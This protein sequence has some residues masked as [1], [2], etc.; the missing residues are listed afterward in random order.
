MNEQIRASQNYRRSIVGLRL[1]SLALLGAFVA[2][3]LM[4][5]PGL[6]AI[7]QILT[8]MVFPVAAVGILMGWIGQLGMIKEFGISVLFKNADT[9][10]RDVFLGIPNRPD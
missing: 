5:G 9:T 10:L 4:A 7:G 2:V 8:L 6:L 1:V 3:V